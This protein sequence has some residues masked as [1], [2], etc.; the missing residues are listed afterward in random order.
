MVSRKKKVLKTA[1]GDG[2]KAFRV[3][4]SSSKRI[5]NELETLVLLLNLMDKYLWTSFNCLQNNIDFTSAKWNVTTG[6]VRWQIVN[7]RFSEFYPH[8]NRIVIILTMATLFLFLLAVTDFRLV[9]HDTSAPDLHRTRT[10]K[11]W[12]RSCYVTKKKNRTIP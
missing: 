6:Q 8:G 3:L 12:Q 2:S 1:W 4:L 11:L 7:E 10:K 5:R 9:F